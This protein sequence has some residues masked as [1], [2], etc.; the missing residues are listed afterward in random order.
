M[1]VNFVAYLF[2]DNPD[3]G[4]KCGS[5]VGDGGREWIIKSLT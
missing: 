5:Y 3:G 2:A 1:V 4:I